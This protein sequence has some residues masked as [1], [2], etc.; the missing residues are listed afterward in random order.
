MVWPGWE[1]WCHLKAADQ[2]TWA[3]AAATTAAAVIALWL[4]V[5]D[6]IRRFY[7]SRERG[8]VALALAFPEIVRIRTALFEIV[9]NFDWLIEAL[10]T[11][12]P[13]RSSGPLVESIEGIAAQLT[14][15]LTAHT[16][17]HYTDMPA[18]F[19]FNLPTVV[20]TLPQMA[21]I[22]SRIRRA[23]RRTRG[24]E[25]L[26]EVIFYRNFVD[27]AL[28]DFNAAVVYIT[29]NLVPQQHDNMRDYMTDEQRARMR[30]GA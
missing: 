17:E 10:K 24:E 16:A 8:R 4:G 27:S 3:S 9:E 20:Q 28:I 6:G 26:K 30:E 25:R 22:G 11:G 12:D 23:F 1:W 19:R 7:E 18:Q 5:R 29:E 21:D 15:P 13:D 2:G 14:T